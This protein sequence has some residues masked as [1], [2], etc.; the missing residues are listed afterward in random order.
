MDSCEFDA[1]DS[2]DKIEDSHSL[3]NESSNNDDSNSIKTNK[4]IDL[5]LK[6]EKER[7][8]KDKDLK[9]SI[10]DSKSFFNPIKILSYL[11][12]VAGFIYL[13]SHHL[14]NLAIYLFSLAVPIITTVW[15]LLN[16]ELKDAT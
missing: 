8:K 2:I 10:K 5:V 3:Y 12:L 1:P 9:K 14:L 4:S 15:V 16:W 6:E 13:N 11:F 7:L